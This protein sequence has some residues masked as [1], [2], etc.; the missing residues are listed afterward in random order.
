MLISHLWD[1]I[2]TC[3]WNYVGIVRSNKR[4]SRALTRV[5]NIEMEIEDYYKNFEINSD[6]IELKNLCAVAK[7]TIQSALQRKVSVGT[8]YNVDLPSNRD[9]ETPWANIAPL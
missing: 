3:M 6:I 7:L 8:H 5:T 1:E 2:R 4:L 9:E